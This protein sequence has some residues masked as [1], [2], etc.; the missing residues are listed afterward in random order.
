MSSSAEGKDGAALAGSP[1][2][3]GDLAVRLVGRVH[4]A[5]LELHAFAFQR[6]V[7]PACRLALSEHVGHRWE[8]NQV[9][10]ALVRPN[11]PSMGVTEDISFDLLDRK[12]TRQNSSHLG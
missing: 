4:T 7:N 11:F 8:I 5:Q 3:L 10:S 12:S 9:N 1:L 2:E 6:G